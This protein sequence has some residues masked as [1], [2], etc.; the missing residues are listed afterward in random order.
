MMSDETIATGIAHNG[1]GQLHGDAD[2]IDSL[3]STHV[4]NQADHSSEYRNLDQ[5]LGI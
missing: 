5:L 4:H 3:T 1:P 2:D